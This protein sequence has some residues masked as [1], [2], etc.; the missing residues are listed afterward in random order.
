MSPKKQD[1][2]QRVLALMRSPHYQPLDKVALSKKL[3]LSPDDRSQLRAVLKELEG[4]GEIARVRKDRYVLPEE[5]ELVTGVLQIHANGNAH[6]LT[7][8]PGQPDLYIASENTGTAMNGD[9]VVTRIIHEGRA[10]I[11]LA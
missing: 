6:L 8:R 1:L 11:D 2:P 5:A 3:G 4:A 10:G 7:E 9:K